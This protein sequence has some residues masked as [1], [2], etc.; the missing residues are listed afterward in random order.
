MPKNKIHTTS[1]VTDCP[2]TSGKLFKECCSPVLSDH[3]LA[4]TPEMLMRSRYTAFAIEDSAFL[5]RS[6]DI[7]TRPRSI[8]FEKNIVWLQ[9]IIEAAPQPEPND[10]S[11]FVVFKASFIQNDTVFEMKEKSFFIRKKC[12][13]FY[14]NGELIT[15]KKAI[16]LKERCPCGSGKKYKRCCRP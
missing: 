13:W 7:S 11:G 16:S 4:A 6:W 3:S 9:L 5:L 8:N 15:Q 1:L 2:C 14:L 10:D 12:L